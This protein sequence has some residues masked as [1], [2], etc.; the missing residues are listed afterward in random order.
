M[1]PPSG[2]RP[3]IAFL[4][5]SLRRT[6]PII[7]TQQLVEGL[8]ALPRSYDIEILHCKA[9][10]DVTF[11]CPTTSL[12]NL[13]HDVRGRY[14]MV[15]STMLRSDLLLAWFGRPAKVRLRISVIHN[16]IDEDLRYLLVGQ[17]LKARFFT[18]LWRHALSRI[19]HLVVSSPFME[20]RYRELVRDDLRC[21]MIPYGIAD[22]LLDGVAAQRQRTPGSPV[23][24]L[25]CG[26]LIARKNFARAI[27]ALRH[28]PDHVLTIVGDGPER[29]A[30][31]N[32]AT[33]EAVSERVH[34]V[35]EDFGLQE[36]LVHT[37]IFLLP[38]CSEGYGLALLQ[39]LGNGIPT[40]CADLPIYRQLM[41][42]SDVVRFDPHST[43]SLVNALLELASDLPGY[44]RRAR[45]VYDRNHRREDMARSYHALIEQSLSEHE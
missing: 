9:A 40:A 36:R 35:G 33:E 31:Q 3:T 7:F 19:G 6:G 16:F 20:Q 34:F 4:L 5:P 41:P 10:G 37:D 23:R 25:V 29:V 18:A 11:P 1:S 24:L 2:E 17:P 30:L 44:G 28:L 21:T 15:L 27:M 14:E 42:A 43:E 39:A 22:P 38:S 12:R 32:L 45:S 13:G 8:V 26:N